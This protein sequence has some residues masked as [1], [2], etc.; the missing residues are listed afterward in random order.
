MQGYRVL[1]DSA[2]NIPGN[3]D[4]GAKGRATRRGAP[5]GTLAQVKVDSTPCA[6]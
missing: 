1:P 6:S 5:D 4:F 2:V 3:Q